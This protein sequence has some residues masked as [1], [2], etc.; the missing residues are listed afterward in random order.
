[1]KKREI[2]T[3]RPWKRIRP[4]GYISHGRFTSLEEPAMPYDSMEYDIITQSDFLREFYPT[5]HAINDPS[6]YPDIYR[7][8][9]IQITDENG[10]PTGKTKKQ[11][12]KE[13]VPRYSFA[14]QQIIATKQIVHLCGNDIQFELNKEQPTGEEENDFSLFREGWLKKDME[15]A[16][17]EAVKSTKITADTAVVGYLNNGEFGYKTLSYLQGDTLYPHYDSITGRPSLLA[18]SYFDYDDQGDKV[19]EWLEVWDKTYLTRFKKNGEKYATITDKLLGMFGFDG[20]SLVSRKIHGFPFLPAAYHRD[21]NGACWS[22]SQ[23]SCDGYEMSFSQMAQNNQAFGF[24]IMYLQGEEVEAMH[25]INGTIKILTMGPD[26]KAGFLDRPDAS[27][28]FMKQLDTLYKMI[29]EQS[30][31]VIPPELRSG[32]LPAAALKILYS[33][34]YEKALTDSAEY[35]PFLNELVRLFTYGYG[36]E[37]R[38]TIDFTNLPLK[39]WIKPYVHINES[40]MV[41]DLA[42]AVQTGFCSRQTASEKISMYSTQSEWDRIIREEKKKQEADLLYQLKSKKE[43]IQA[44]PHETPHK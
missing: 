13:L 20:Y 30:F 6:I 16:F 19:V 39:W 12:Y 14:F 40:S 10:E 18:R 32:D 26:D 2:K 25:D 35:Q 9:V 8:E 37:V 36:V 5:G 31:A 41:A 44:K 11:I 3:K 29:Y 23:D 7:E 24:P 33:P 15:I 38:K 21:E 27:Q 4:S 34:A 42:T 43:P 1:M 22:P 17:Y 28:S